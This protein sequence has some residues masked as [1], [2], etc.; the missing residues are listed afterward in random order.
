M[1]IKIGDI[2]AMKIKGSVCIYSPSEEI[3][4]VVMPRERGEYYD[5]NI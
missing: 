1:Y 4:Q 3:T 2:C 5:E